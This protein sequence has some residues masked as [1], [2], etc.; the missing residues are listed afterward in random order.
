MHP[1]NSSRALV[2]TARSVFEYALLSPSEQ[3]TSFVGFFCGLVLG[4]IVVSV[5]FLPATAAS[6]FVAFSRSSEEFVIDVVVVGGGGVAG[7]DGGSDGGDGVCSCNVSPRTG[8]IAGVCA[9]ATA[10]SFSGVDP[11][12]RG[13]DNGDHGGEGNGLVDVKARSLS[14]SLISPLLPPTSAASAAA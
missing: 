4:F 1:L 14:Q 8:V 3:Q 7:G 5:T 9:C 2:T 12:D 6:R 11:V 10:L 13:G